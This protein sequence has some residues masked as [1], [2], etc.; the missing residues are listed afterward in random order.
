[1]CNISTI[2]REYFQKSAVDV[3]VV[4]IFGS[5]ARNTNR[6]NSDLDIGILFQHAPGRALMD[7]P[8]PL[9]DELRELCGLQ[10]QLVVLN[11][12]PADLVH[13]ILRDGEIVYEGDPGRRI[14]FEVQKR[15]EYFDLEGVR[16]DY[17]RSVG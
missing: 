8:F 12:A 1:M 14:Q 15:N 2:V 7:Q 11:G 5:R 3:D 10:V 4:Y 16:R 13:R 6:S 17:R 9:E